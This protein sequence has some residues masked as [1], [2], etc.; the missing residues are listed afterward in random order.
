[1]T[2]NTLRPQS[3]LAKARSRRTCAKSLAA[4][5]TAARYLRDRTANMPFENASRGPTPASENDAAISARFVLKVD[6][7][8]NR[9]AELRYARAVLLSGRPCRSGGVRADSARSPSIKGFGRRRQG[10]LVTWC[11][12]FWTGCPVCSHFSIV[13]RRRG[14]DVLAPTSAQPGKVVGLALQFRSRLGHEATGGNCPS[15]QVG[16][17]PPIRLASF[18]GSAEA[19]I[20]R[21]LNGCSAPDR[22]GGVPVG[23]IRR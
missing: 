10:L 18:S 9:K 2:G 13:A 6:A 20:I 17:G 16:A 5:G 14:A 21:H 22:S 4:A 12:A 23:V 15:I 19:S 1:M 8:R 7:T 3:D 11:G